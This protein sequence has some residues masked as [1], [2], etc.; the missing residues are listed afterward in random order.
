MSVYVSVAVALTELEAHT[1]GTPGGTCAACGQ[2]E[3]CAARNA[4][5]AVL[6]AGGVLPR[7]RPGHAGSHWLVAK[8]VGAHR[9]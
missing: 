1:R 2:R 8:Q 6:F 4:A 9:L 5:H 3:P 7:R